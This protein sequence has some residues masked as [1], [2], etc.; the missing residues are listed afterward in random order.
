MHGLI[1]ETSVCYWQNQPGCYLC[2][3]RSVPE[4]TDREESHTKPTS[5]S[6]TV[7]SFFQNCPSN[8]NTD[9]IN[10]A[11]LQFA[12]KQ[13]DK[14]SPAVPFINSQALRRNHASKRTASRAPSLT[15][16]TQFRQ[17]HISHR[18]VSRPE[19]EVGDSHDLRARPRTAPSETQR[20]FTARRRV[21][22]S[23]NLLLLS[24]SAQIV[25]GSRSTTQS[26][27][28][29]NSTRRGINLAL[30]DSFSCP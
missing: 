24:S 16:L 19:S 17:K 26:S 20:K 6:Q 14:P 2:S 25:S 4:S 8:A 1:F 3:T 10:D 7:R 11:S 29:A 13:T 23:N 28:L 15:P 30:A 21:P 12:M 9:R 18:N 5:R 27:N 22:C